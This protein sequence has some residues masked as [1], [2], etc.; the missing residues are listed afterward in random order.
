MTSGFGVQIAWVGLEIQNLGYLK[1]L[2]FLSF[3]FLFFSFMELFTLKH[4]M[5]VDFPFPLCD[6]GHQTGFI[7]S[8]VGLR[9]RGS[10]S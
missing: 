2:V 4:L 3:F 6:I 5:S 9:D 10:I 1:N 8:G 7:G